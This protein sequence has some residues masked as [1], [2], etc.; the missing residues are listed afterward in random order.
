MEMSEGGRAVSSTELWSARHA[1]I[2]GARCGDTKI[3]YL[4]LNTSPVVVYTA[5]DERDG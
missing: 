1:Q 2:A 3:R 5:F 4:Q